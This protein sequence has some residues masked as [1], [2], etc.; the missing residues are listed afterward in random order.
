MKRLARGRIIVRQAFAKRFSLI[1]KI[2]APFI[3]IRL[4]VEKAGPRCGVDGRYECRFFGIDGL[5]C[6]VFDDGVMGRRVC[7]NEEEGI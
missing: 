7:A 2:I 6:S 5:F 1:Q 3:S 4:P